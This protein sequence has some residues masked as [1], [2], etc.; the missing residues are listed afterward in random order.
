VNNSNCSTNSSSSNSNSNSSS[1]SSSSTSSSMNACIVMNNN[2]LLT[3]SSQNHLMNINTIDNIDLDTSTLSVSH[4]H[5]NF[6]DSNEFK[7]NRLENISPNNETYKTVKTGL[8]EFSTFV[9]KM[10]RQGINY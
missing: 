9:S 6:M 7:P 4:Q 1:S 2:Q 5:N 8:R 10:V 3:Q